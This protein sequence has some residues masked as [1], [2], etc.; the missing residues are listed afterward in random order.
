MAVWFVTVGSLVQTNEVGFNS[1]PVVIPLV[2]CLLSMS[3]PSGSQAVDWFISH[4]VSLRPTR[5]VGRS[6]KQKVVHPHHWTRVATAQ[7]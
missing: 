4:T 7:P 2:F 1:V 5:L 6:G 3:E